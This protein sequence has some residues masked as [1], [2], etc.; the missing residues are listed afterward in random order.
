MVET[1]YRLHDDTR[2]E[3]VVQDQNIHYIHMQFAQ[4]D[5]LPVHRA[6]SNL[7]MT[8]LRG[9]LT[10]A[11]DGLAAHAYERGT[12]LMIPVGTQMDVRNTAPDMLE[13]I[14]VKAPAPTA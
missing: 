13:L 11:L 8:V 5:G 12:V 9:M 4:G 1:V 3:K 14:V 2:I 10:I 6:N 7:Y